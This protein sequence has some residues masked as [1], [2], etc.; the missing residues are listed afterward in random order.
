MKRNRAKYWASRSFGVS[1]LSRPPHSHRWLWRGLAVLPLLAFAAANIATAA[2]QSE[3]EQAL[4]ARSAIV[5]RGKILRVNASDEPL[6]AASSSTAVIRILEMRSGREIAGDQVGSTATVILS[7]SGG[8]RAGVEALFF[9]NPRFL[10][11]TL[12]IADEGE[13]VASAATDAMTAAVESSAKLRQDG[14]VTARIASASQV[15]RGVVEDIQRL[16][17]AG[18]V[19]DEA[20]RAPAS[21]HEPEWS[22]ASVRVVDPIRGAAKDALVKIVFAASQDIEWFNS[23]KPKPGQE[24]IFLTQKPDAE[25]G[26]QLLAVGASEGRLA[27]ILS[28][29]Q[30]MLPVAEESRIQSLIVRE[31][32]SK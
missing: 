24:A 23:P 14:L 17:T 7:R 11:T 2:A 8:L 15:F 1:F 28:A 32:E 26:P 12:T 10:G 22:V 13:I 4:L 25:Q 6:V 21:E 18:G 16:G 5:V 27:E 29:P 3:S 9:G 31:K 30:D 20:K 19:G